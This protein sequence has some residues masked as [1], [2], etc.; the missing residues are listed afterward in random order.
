METRFVGRS[1]LQVSE[2]CLGTMTFGADRGTDE[3]TAHQ[4]LDAFVD[5]GGTFIDTANVYSQGAS[6]EILGRW[7]KTHNRDDLVIATKVYGE[8]APGQPPRG[9]GRKHVLAEVEASLWRLQTDFIDLYQAHVF[10]DATPFEETLS[11]L[12]SLVS[13]GKVRFIGASNYAGWQL[14]KSIELSR[15]HGWEPFV[16]LQPLYNLL[17]R[18]AELE[19]LP[20]CRNEGVGVIAWSPLAGGWLSGKYTR[21]LG[22]PPVGARA[23]DEEWAGRNS[24]RTWRVIETVQAVAAEVDRTPA[25]VALRWVLQQPGMTG[26]IIGARTSDQLA[27][28]L[29]ATGWA[30]D[31]D[32]LRRLTGAGDQQLPYPYELQRLPQF[33]RRPT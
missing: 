25:Q 24:D 20:L 15:H 22:G 11:T 29:G 12:D 8:A 17:D 5:T 32:Q 4:I 33:V 31:A 3:A 21:D 14:Q 23:G 6:E 7:L 16:S 10:D 18:G 27:D 30:L 28:N 1:G 26:P 19:L 2:L 9:T 13:S